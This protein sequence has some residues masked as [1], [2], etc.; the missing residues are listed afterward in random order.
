MSCQTSFSRSPM[1]LN[2][3]TLQT[4][5][6]ANSKVNTE[7]KINIPKIL[8]SKPMG[9][10]SIAIAICISSFGLPRIVAA[11]NLPEAFPF[12]SEKPAFSR[13]MILTSPYTVGGYPVYHGGERW[14]VLNSTETKNNLQVRFGEL[15][16]VLIES[17]EIAA[18]LRIFANLDRSSSEGTYYTSDFCA[19]RNDQ[20]VRHNHPQGQYDDCLII[21]PL[22][23]SIR[24]QQTNVIEVIVNISKSGDR[25]YRKIFKVNPVRAGF[26]PDASWTR[27]AIASDRR[28]AAYLSRLEAWGRSIH[29][30][31]DT[32][33]DWKKPAD[34]YANVAPIASV[35]L[36]VNE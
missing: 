35:L 17:G 9:W 16:L 28:K 21:R 24:G 31:A 20:L 8:R 32:A 25:L 27:E 36:P 11:Q 19:I 1:G 7:Q 22:T 33:T 14:I 29:E 13:Q 6:Q 18:D 2:S 10:L 4:Q 12:R 34:A 5:N 3:H 26:P 30:A 23:I 15:W